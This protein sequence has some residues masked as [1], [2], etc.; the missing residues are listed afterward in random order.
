M[1]SDSLPSTDR[2]LAFLGHLSILLPGLGLLAPL[3]LWTIGHRRS[4]GLRFQLL[5]AAALQVIQPVAALLAGLIL[6]IVEL[7]WLLVDGQLR[8]FPGG[9][10]RSL[11]GLLGPYLLYIAGLYL[12]VS[13]AFVGLGIAAG[14]ACRQGRSY[15][16]PWLGNR[17][18]A[19]LDAQPDEHEQNC[20]ASLCHL[21]LFNG[22]SGLAGC[23]LVWNVSR[24][25]EDAFLR[26][27]AQQAALYQAAGLVVELLATISVAW[28]LA[29]G[30]VTL[31][32]NRGEFGGAAG[33]ATAIFGLLAL[34]CAFVIILAVPVFQTLPIVATAR[35]LCGRDYLYPFLGKWLS[36]RSHL[37][38]IRR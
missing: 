6:A 2:S 24:K 32:L 37:F 26:F 4:G 22:L 19:Y 27:Q 31:A 25:D 14:V 23:I 8:A 17:L 7:V 38:Y 28:L 16:Y 15:R 34:L 11:T 30:G 21:G 1:N 35:F 29:M 5:Q 33:L 9:E 13:L 36:K 18:A 12:L 10:P 3:I 20:L